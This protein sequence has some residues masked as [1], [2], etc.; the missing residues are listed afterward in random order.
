ME[1]T[2][3]MS[4][5]DNTTNSQFRTLVSHSSSKYEWLIWAFDNG[6]LVP[7]EILETDIALGERTENLLKKQGQY[8]STGIQYTHIVCPPV[9]NKMV[10][11]I[12][13]KG[14]T[15]MM[16]VIVKYINYMLG[17][18]NIYMYNPI[19]KGSGYRYY[20][21][22]RCVVYQVGKNETRQTMNALRKTI[23]DK[24]FSEKIEIVLTQTNIRSFLDFSYT[25]IEYTTIQN[26][27]KKLIDLW[28]R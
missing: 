19:G 12:S 16:H 23:K 20:A 2:N 24:G 7:H 25:K 26:V 17:P 4:Y 1:L 6:Y 13:G 15:R 9:S 3:T 27:K 5:R 18:T 22:E 11:N 21:G 10:I 8:Y 28:N 14:S